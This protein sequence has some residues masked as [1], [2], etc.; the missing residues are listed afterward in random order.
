M[1]I[2]NF[3]VGFMKFDVYCENILNEVSQQL[4]LE[5]VNFPPKYIDK[6]NNLVNK[7]Q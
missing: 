1:K 6:N 4:L 7:Y 5:Y 3:T 2:F